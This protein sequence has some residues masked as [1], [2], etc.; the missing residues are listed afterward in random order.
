METSANVKAMAKN[1]LRPIRW[2][3]RAASIML[4]N[5]PTW[6]IIDATPD[7]IVSRPAI[8]RSESP[9]AS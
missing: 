8:S 5:A 2:Q 4:T 6:I 1:D 7:Q 3:I 9:C